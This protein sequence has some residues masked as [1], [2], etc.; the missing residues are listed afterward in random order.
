LSGPPGGLAVIKRVRERRYG[1]KIPRRSTVAMSELPDP[2]S[3]IW[4]KEV[5][6]RCELVEIRER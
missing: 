5:H 1:I 2:P 6:L 3:V 4:G